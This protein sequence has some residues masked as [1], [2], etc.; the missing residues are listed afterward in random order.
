[1]PW[2]K[3]ADGNTYQSGGS[4]LPAN[5]TPFPFIWLGNFSGG[6]LDASGTP[7]PQFDDASLG[8]TGPTSALT[9][10]AR[11]LAAYLRGFQNTYGVPFYAISIQNELDFD[12]F[13]N[14]CFYPQPAGYLAALKAVRT[15][16]DKYP[17]LAGI[18]LMGP[19]DV[20]GGDPYGMWQYGSG[21]TAAAKNLQFIQGIGGDP[22]AASAES[23]FCI[24][25]YASDGVS[26]A[27]ATPTQWAWWVQGWGTSPGAGIPPNV[28]GFTNYGKKSWMTETS[29][30]GTAWL[31][32]ATGFPGSGAFS[33]ALRIQQALTTG[34]ESAWA[35]W[36]MTDGNPVGN[37][38]LTD[39]TNLQNSP[40]YVAAKHFFRYIRPNALCVNATVAGS[41]T[42]SSSAFW[43]QTNGTMTVVLINTTNTAVQAVINSPAQPAGI[44]SWQTFTSSN[45]NYWQNS[46]NTITNGV[47]TV[48]VPGYGV[49][50]L[51][52]VGT[53]GLRAAPATNGQLNLFWPPTATGFALQ[54]TTNLAGSSWTNL[55]GGQITTNG[56]SN[57]LVSVT[58]RQNSGTAFYRLALP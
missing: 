42:L 56:L 8:G 43:H 39:S 34:R 5:G 1:M 36:Q 55:A 2:V 58:V 4:A 37:E 31:S 6:K 38:T 20:L 40:K 16:L 30:E 25:G 9:Q 57:G 13:Y 23:F 50:T 18:K 22:A 45:G 53:P 24:H 54:S 47:A 19:E 35:Y 21:N 27:T 48:S 33:L 44:T 41:A 17:D 10:F 49:V 3:V 32:P 26:S 15:E 52:G 46:T 14:S 11:C 12:E 51:Y 7:L 28:A 29:G